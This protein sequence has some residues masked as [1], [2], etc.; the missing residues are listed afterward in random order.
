[1][2]FDQESP[3]AVSLPNNGSQP[4]W[5]TPLALKSTRKTNPDAEVNPV[6][7]KTKDF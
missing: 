7:H 4:L 2:V 1:M 5:V 3:S 6:R